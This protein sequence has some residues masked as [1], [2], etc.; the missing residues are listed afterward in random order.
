MDIEFE[1]EMGERDAKMAKTDV[2]PD[3][4]G[5]DFL[6]RVLYHNGKYYSNSQEL[7]FKSKL[8]YDQDVDKAIDYLKQSFWQYGTN[9]AKYNYTKDQFKLASPCYCTLVPRCHLHH[10][11]SGGCLSPLGEVIP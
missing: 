11:R 6:A 8:C 10:L 1:R 5:L 3:W 7:L 9:E 2:S 4:S